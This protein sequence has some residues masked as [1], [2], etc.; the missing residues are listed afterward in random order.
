M[1]PSC[2]K[3]NGW[4]EVLKEF[5]AG[6]NITVKAIEYL[7]ERDADLTTRVLVALYEANPLRG[8]CF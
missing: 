8:G 1:V 7:M 2:L 4:E 3:F 5:F 6:I